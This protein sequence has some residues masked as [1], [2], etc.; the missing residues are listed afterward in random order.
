MGGKGDFPFFSIVIATSPK[1]VWGKL[2]WVRYS[3]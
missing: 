1:Q 2:L 3:P